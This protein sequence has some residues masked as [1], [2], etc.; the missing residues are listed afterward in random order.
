M[1]TANPIRYDIVGP[2]VA[3][4]VV[5]PRLRVRAAASAPFAALNRSLSV[6]TV[7][8]YGHR[9][10]QFDD[11]TRVVRVAAS[12]SDPVH[13][14]PVRLSVV[15]GVGSYAAVTMRAPYV[16]QWSLALVT[17]HWLVMLSV[18]VAEGV[19]ERLVVVVPPSAITDDRHRLGDQPQLVLQVSGPPSHT[20]HIGRTL[21]SQ[22]CPSAP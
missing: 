19:P 22:P 9:L 2:P 13:L 12:P 7:D 11:A 20:P 14:P 18:L 5:P 15:R 16:G 6:Y 10:L 17:G 21:L 4:E 8:A 3:L 1:F